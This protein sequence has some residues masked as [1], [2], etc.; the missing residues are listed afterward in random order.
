[1]EARKHRSG[2]EWEHGR[3]TGRPERMRAV[4]AGG[5]VAGLE[6]LLA[7]SALAGELVEIDLVSPDEE[8]VFRPMLVAEP[9]GA[10]EV[11]R[12]DLS[13]IVAAA[14]ATHVRDAVASVDAAGRTVATADGQTL[15]YQALLIAVGARPVEAVPGALTFS[16]ADE[17]RRFGDMLRALGRRGARRLVFIVPPGVSW[18][19]AAYE[20]AL[21]TAAER[22]ARRL[23]GVELLVVTH[24]SVPLEPLGAAASQLLA[25]RLDEAG[26]AVETKRVATRVDEAQL[27]LSSGQA[28]EGTGFV[29]LPALEVDPIPGLP[30]REGGFV[31][32]DAR[33][34]VAGLESVWASGDVTWF[35]IKQGGLAAQ[36]ADAAARAI[37]AIAGAHVPIEPFHPVLRAALITGG[38]PDFLRSG[39]PSRGPADTSAGRALWWPPAKVAGRYLGP[40]IAAKLGEEPGAGELVDLEAPTDA[41]AD[42]AE[43]EQAVALILAAADA[44]AAA[45]DYDGALKWLAFAE[46]LDLV[47]PA[48]YVARRYEWR[49]QLEPSLDVDSAAARIDPTF[50]S[51]EA[52]LL[53]LGRRLAWL[54]EL[55]GQ[56]ED[57]MRRRLSD[58]DSQMEHLRGLTKRAG[59]FKPG[60]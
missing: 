52:A 30:Q 26:V 15:A 49:R 39:L 58:L 51:S 47:I 36:Q 16:G 21:L 59:I 42:A 38:T 22:D 9:F 4:V 6:A 13:E 7:L 29:A 24:E 17:R 50:E 2:D 5:G 56:T 25:A 19:I 57:E 55:G 54:R 44:D 34:H 35:P 23:P 11:L 3:M 12:F 1:M 20:L 31:Q 32:T 14:G 28:I 53:E 27:I 33:M 18:S 37:A 45:D 8:F 43:H 41:D 60:D 48:R 10:G 46:Q 40:Y